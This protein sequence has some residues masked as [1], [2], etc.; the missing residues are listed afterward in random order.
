ML[1]GAGARSLR[2]SSLASASLA[3]LSS[4][5]LAFDWILAGLGLIWLG[6][7]LRLDFG[8]IWIWLDLALA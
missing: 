7:R 1:S 8:V 5:W 4:F 6:F 3:R 2:S